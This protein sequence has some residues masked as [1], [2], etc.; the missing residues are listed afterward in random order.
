MT[1]TSIEFIVFFLC[2]WALY[3]CLTTHA[4]NRLLV[5]S[6]MLFY[7]WWDSRFLLLLF[8]TAVVDH[9]IAGRISHERNERLRNVLLISSVVF[10]LTILGFF[11]YFNFF[12]SSFTSSMNLIGVRVSHETISIVLPVGISFYTFHVICG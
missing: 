12:A 1:F 11:K 10:N 4:Q 9:V 7:G 6:S 5:L 8:A 2:T 3:L